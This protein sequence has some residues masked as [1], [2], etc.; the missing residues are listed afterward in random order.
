[1]VRTTRPS[2]AIRMKAFGTNSS[3]S[4]AL[5]WPNG[6]LRPS[7]RPPPAAAPLTRKLRRDSLVSSGRDAIPRNI[8]SLSLCVRL[9][10]KLDGLADTHIGPAPTDVST[11]GV[12]DFCIGR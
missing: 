9:R 2:P 4:A 8:M 11:H 10:G 3:E 6:R 1:M 7:I 12:V 5:D